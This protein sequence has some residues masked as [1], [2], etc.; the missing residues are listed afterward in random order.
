MKKHPKYYCPF[1]SLTV[2]LPTSGCFKHYNEKF[3]SILQVVT[4]TRE[5]VS[6]SVLKETYLN[7]KNW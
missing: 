3:S 6:S 7:D 2:C 1:K 5:K 4:Y